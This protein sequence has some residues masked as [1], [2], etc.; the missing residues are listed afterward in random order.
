MGV[1]VR[2]F[3]NPQ[4]VY[5]REGDRPSA[6]LQSILD[7]G[8][9]AVPV[10]DDDERPVAIVSLRDLAD[11]K[12]PA[13]RSTTPVVSA[14]IDDPIRSAAETLARAS[15]HHLVVVD[16]AGRAV[17]MLSAVDVV[18]ALLGLEASHPKAIADFGRMH[19]A[20]AAR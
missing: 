12:K 7:F 19:V 9:T 16:D 5:M 3:M 6:A 14:G 17:G 8:I 10:L 18:R 1:K 15:V 13:S 20:D 2:D 11:A 4:L